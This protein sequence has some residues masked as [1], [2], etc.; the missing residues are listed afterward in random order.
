MLNMAKLKPFSSPT[1]CVNMPLATRKRKKRSGSAGTLQV[2]SKRKAKEHVRSMGDQVR[3]PEPTM[4]L[5]QSGLLS[6]FERTDKPYVPEEL[7]EMTAAA[8]ALPT[9]ESLAEAGP[10]LTEGMCSMVSYKGLRFRVD[11]HLASP[12]AL[13][14]V[15]NLRD[16]E[17]SVH[18]K[19]NAW[20]LHL[21]RD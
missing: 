14:R 10:P 15:P 6:T 20:L 8:A 3:A 1:R 5:R 7:S 11:L 4:R 12:K 19:A 16:P 18:L 13:G 9:S 21:F 17:R 2:P